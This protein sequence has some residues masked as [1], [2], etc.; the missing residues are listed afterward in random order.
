MK[1]SIKG[2]LAAGSAAALLL[3]GAGSLAYWTDSAT[4]AGGDITSGDLTLT[5]IA[6]ADWQLDSD[7]GTGGPLAGRLIVPGDTLTKTCTYTLHATGEHLEGTL[8]VDTPAWAGDLA[9]KVTTGATFTVG[10]TP[11]TPGTPVTFQDGPDQ[12]V[13]AAFTVDFPYGTE[14]NSS[15]DLTA[16]LDDITV[17][18]T[19]TDNH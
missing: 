5:T 4:V 19:Q 18:V 13:T 11:V 16:T 2:A 15:K 3:G 12:T 7:G 10:T 8:D 9:G 14:D 1:K 17:T 6:C